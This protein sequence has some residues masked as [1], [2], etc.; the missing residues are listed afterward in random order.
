LINDRH[1]LY[2]VLRKIPAA[3]IEIMAITIAALFGVSVLMQS[4]ACKQKGEK[5][6]FNSFEYIL[7]NGHIYLYLII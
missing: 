4:T 7:V 6:T 5:E 3:T 2:A 1:V